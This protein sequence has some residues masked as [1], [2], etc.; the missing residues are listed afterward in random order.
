MQ[1]SEF[2]VDFSH[3]LFKA[4]KKSISEVVLNKNI[5]IEDKEEAHI[6][7]FNNMFTEQFSQ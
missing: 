4:M 5:N 6:E 1:K 3:L 2:M 7:L